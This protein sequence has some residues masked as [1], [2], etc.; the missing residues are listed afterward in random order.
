VTRI[1]IVEDDP[2]QARVLARA[3]S[4]RRPGYTVLTSENGL[5]ATRLLREEEV[6]VVLADLQMP[7]MNGFELLAWLLEHRPSLPVFT[8]TAYGNEQTRNQL[9]AYGSVECFT[10]P[11]DIETVVE[12]M[13]ESLSRDVRGHVR[14]MN[15]VPFLQL[16]ELERMTCTLNVEREGRRGTLF[17]RQG[18]LLD[19]RLDELAGE[20]AAL[21]L[22]A[23]SNASITISGNCTLSH[24]SIDKPFSFILMESLRLHDERARARSAESGDPVPPSL[25][26]ATQ[27][28]LSLP[29][30][31]LAIAV[32]DVETGTLL[33][34]GDRDGVA[35]QELILLAANV[36]RHEMRLVS[37]LNL[38]GEAVEELVLSSQ[39]YCEV[40]QPLATVPAF[41]LAVF[42]PEETNLMMAR[43]ELR[44]LVTDLRWMGPQ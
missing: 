24:R 5:S 32:V 7:E 12:R 31:L 23:W 2:A 14:N 34:C 43:L 18:E 15:L 1:L 4:M 39:T 28:S 11:I 35:T 22:V 27:R 19:A 17:V 33:A 38:A 42:D 41:A 3:I 10:K 30:N 29:P 36:Y 13:S 37:S 26:D 40:I 6:D 9:S 21:E 44:R 20:P 8:M 25:L 16:L